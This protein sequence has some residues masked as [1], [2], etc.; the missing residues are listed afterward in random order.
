MDSIEEYDRES[1]AAT[2]SPGYLTGVPALKPHAWPFNGQHHI[3][4]IKLG[5]NNIHPFI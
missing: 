1:D 2:A 5:G 3:R 4:K